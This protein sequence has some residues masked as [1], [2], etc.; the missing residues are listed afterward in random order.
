MLQVQK[1]GPDNFDFWLHTWDVHNKRRK[2]RSLYDDPER[3]REAEWEEFSAVCGMG[4]KYCDGRVM[5]DHF[6][7]A[8]PKVVVRRGTR[9]DIPDAVGKN[10]ERYSWIVVL[11]WSGNTKGTRACTK[12]VG[13]LKMF[14]SR[15]CKIRTLRLKLI[16]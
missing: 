6:E 15:E 11:T 16:A 12:S 3:N 7:D 13:T 4:T 1:P 10:L 2:V 14:R 8:I 9:P 5:V